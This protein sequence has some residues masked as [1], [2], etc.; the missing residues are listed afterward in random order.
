LQDPGELAEEGNRVRDVLEHL[1]GRHQVEGCGWKRQFEPGRDDELGAAVPRPLLRGF[2]GT[3]RDVHADDPVGDRHEP[4]R[5]VPGI[6][7]DIEHIAPGRMGDRLVIGA[8][9]HQPQAVLRRGRRRH[10]LDERVLLGLEPDRLDVAVD[11]SRQPRDVH[12]P[13]YREGRPRDARAA[14]RE[15]VAARV[16][17]LRRCP[18]D[19]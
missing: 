12:R 13:E 4:E 6:A 3:R 15:R 9:V 2:N 1:E 10:V 5:A 11:R 19:S 8:E 16:D 18:L 17:R 7:A 14:T